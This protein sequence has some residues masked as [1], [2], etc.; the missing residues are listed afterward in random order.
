[1]DSQL[2]LTDAGVW[3]KLNMEGQM[4]RLPSG[5]V[6]KLRPISLVNLMKAKSIPNHLMT[7][8]T[9][10]LDGLGDFT[11]EMAV[12]AGELMDI[13]AA[14]SLVYPKVV[15]NPTEEDEISVGDIP[16]QDKYY[17]LSWA[18]APVVDLSFSSEEEEDALE[19]TSDQQDLPSTTE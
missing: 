1:M 3:R 14:H 9:N 6:C 4:V 17:I 2:K 13:V 11:P 19:F 5:M 15:G 10:A 7:L 12:D 16:S 8:A 18:Q